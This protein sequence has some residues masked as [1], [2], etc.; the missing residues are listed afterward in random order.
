MSTLLE[1]LKAGQAKAK[2]ELEEAPKAEA[3]KV[4]A[5][6][7]EAPKVEAPKPK[8]VTPQV[9]GLLAKLQ[10]SGKGSPQLGGE[11]AQAVSKSKGFEISPHSGLAGHGELAGVHVKTVEEL[12]QV[13]EGILPPDA[14]P[15][16]EPP[17][18][19]TIAKVTAKVE[20]AAEEPVEKPKKKRKG[21]PKGSKN[22]VTA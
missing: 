17:V 9:N 6:K 19:A 8:S 22:K 5:P 12:S 14:P 13:A 10:A 15:R 20:E 18:A 2:A 16:E 11:V 21:R 3:P 4:E 1:R 7:V